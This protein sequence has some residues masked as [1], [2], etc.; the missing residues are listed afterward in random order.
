MTKQLTV[1]FGRGST[2][3]L[4]FGSKLGVS[5]GLGPCAQLR[6]L[7]RLRTLKAPDRRRRRVRPVW[8]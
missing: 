6:V 3:L 8:W 4:T 2:G 5:V 7:S 1:T